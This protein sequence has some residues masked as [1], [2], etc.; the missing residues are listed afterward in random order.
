M[1]VCETTVLTR[2]YL[3]FPYD[4]GAL[5]MEECW[6]IERN[7]LLQCE[8]N[9]IQYFKK[10]ICFI[11]SYYTYKRCNLSRYGRN[12]VLNKIMQRAKINKRDYKNLI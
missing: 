8:I 12:K 2:F 11:I 7:Q 9:R 4:V 10:K 1:V 3:F 5:F 6:I